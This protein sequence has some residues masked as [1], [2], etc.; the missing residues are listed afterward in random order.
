M[1][2]GIVIKSIVSHSDERQT[3]RE[4]IRVTDSFFGEGFGQFSHAIMLPSTA[5]GWH[6]HKTQVD[7]WYVPIGALVLALHDKR[8][9][10]NFWANPRDF[11]G[12]YLPTDCG[13][14]SARRSAWMS[15]HWWGYTLVLYHII[16]L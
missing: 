16:Y 2:E 1:I 13:K 7:W 12:R 6:I 3:F 9:G 14:N 8:E 15:C 11:D 10:A 4:I 5:K